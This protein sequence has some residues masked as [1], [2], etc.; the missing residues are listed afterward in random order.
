MFI[1]KVEKSVPIFQ[2]DKLKINQSVL[3]PAIISEA[4]GTN[5]IEKGWSGYLDKFYSKGKI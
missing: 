1:E 3:G 2:R 4:T 5:I